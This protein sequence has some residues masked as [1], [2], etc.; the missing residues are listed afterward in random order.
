MLDIRKVENL[1]GSATLP[2]VTQRLHAKKLTSNFDGR[3]VKVVNEKD[4]NLLR[5]FNN[6]NWSNKD[7]LYG[8]NKDLLYKSLMNSVREKRQFGL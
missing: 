4:S 8:N 7:S 3:N 2:V 6:L 1:T 5:Q